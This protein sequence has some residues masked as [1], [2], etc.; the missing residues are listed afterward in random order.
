MRNER[1]EEIGRLK[2]GAQIQDVSGDL[3]SCKTN[4]IE[5]IEV[6]EGRLSFS[7][8]FFSPCISDLANSVSVSRSR[9]L[10]LSESGGG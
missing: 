6:C 8:M 9:S 1:G 10:G 2:E 7:L 4:N 3:L 5:S